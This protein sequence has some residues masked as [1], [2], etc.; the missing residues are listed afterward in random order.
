MNAGVDEIGHFKETFWNYYKS[1]EK[2][3]LELQDYVAFRRGNFRACSNEII[4]LVLLV[5][6]E[7]D[8]L[9]KY[10]C[11]FKLEEDHNIA[12][13]RNWLVENWRSID[14]IT[15]ELVE[16]RIKLHPFKDW[17]TSSNIASPR[18]W[19]SYNF[20]KHD[21]SD[22]YSRGNLGTLLY[23]LSALYAL[24]LFAFKC[25]TDRCNTEATLEDGA[26]RY[27]DIPPDSGRLF[28]LIGWNTY[29]MPMLETYTVRSDIEN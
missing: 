13:Y 27:I 9:S 17:N 10:V 2:R 20:V 24:E 22:N 16:K 12:E 4:S 14:H 25:V 8:H 26:P 5:G 29:Y 28:K 11:G 23:A 19:R 6:A 18:W 15:V 1:I 3:V 7:F 21:R